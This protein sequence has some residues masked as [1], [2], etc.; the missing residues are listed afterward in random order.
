MINPTLQSQTRVPQRGGTRLSDIAIIAVTFLGLF[1]VLIWLVGSQGVEDTPENFGSSHSSGPRGTLAL[2]RWLERTG[3]EV[4][5]TERGD[6]FPPEADTL[7]MVNPNNDFPT[8]QAGTVRRWVE[9]G[10]TLVLTLGGA[11]IGLGDKHPMLREF[12]FDV[13]YTSFF[14]DTVPMSQPMFGRPSVVQVGMPG[15]VVLALPLTNTVP[16]ATTTDYTGDR[17]PLA[18]MMRVGQGRV[19][20][21]SSQFPLTNEGIREPGNG[22]FAYNML[23]MAA[24]NRVTFDEAHHGESTGGDLVALLTSTPWGLA[25]IYGA[26][27][28]AIYFI[29]SARRLGPPLP[30]LAPDQRRPTSEYVT[31]VAR[32]FRRARKPGY[33]AERY[34]RFLKRTLSRH[35]ELDPYL[36]DTNFVRSLGERGRHDFNQEEMLRAIQQLRDLEGNASGN[37]ATEEAALRALRD[38]ERV[39]LEALGIRG[40]EA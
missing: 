35:A 5:R 11:S 1:A 19:F 31:S 27:L 37:E 30:V 7:I 34:L 28:G 23:Q 29:W 4:S 2:Y 25:L 38:A 6:R 14:T 22:A 20:L 21:L 9:E 8:G 40:D 26:V 3:F 24:G 16:L 32:L 33:A 39:R 13:I 18:A 17:V 36:T 15:S 12:G 10:H